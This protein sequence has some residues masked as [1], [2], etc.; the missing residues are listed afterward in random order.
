MNL[1]DFLK[2]WLLLAGKICGKP[3]LR[4]DVHRVGREREPS[5][6]TWTSDWFWD[7][8][9]TCLA[10]PETSAPQDRCLGLQLLLLVKLL[11]QKHG[12]PPKKA[13]VNRHQCWT[14]ASLGIGQDGVGAACPGG[15][16]A[17]GPGWEA[18]TAV[19]LLLSPVTDQKEWKLVVFPYYLDVCGKGQR[20]IAVNDF[21]IENH[22]SVLQSVRK[23]LIQKECDYKIT[24]HFWAHHLQTFL[25]SGTALPTWIGVLLEYTPVF[26]WGEKIIHAYTSVARI[27]IDDLWNGM[28][29]TKLDA[30]GVRSWVCWRSGIQ[31]RPTLWFMDHVKGLIAYSSLKKS[32]SA[33]SNKSGSTR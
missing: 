9:A 6:C 7:G 10:T 11:P 4:G 13:R 16:K 1:K 21:C 5:P 19:G 14:Q 20:G 25:T 22:S 18:C 28:Q 32:Y 8:P 27:Y 26:T 23:M 3:F 2:K 30:P 12:C 17:V 15:C 31:G 24:L 33:V 29:G